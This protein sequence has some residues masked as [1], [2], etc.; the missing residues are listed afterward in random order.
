MA[1][2]KIQGWGGGSKKVE[3]EILGE[4]GGGTGNESKREG[5]VINRVAIGQWTW[6]GPEQWQLTI[7][8]SLS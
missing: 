6:F 5:K 8:K 3:V 1:G 7:S 2:L 4:R